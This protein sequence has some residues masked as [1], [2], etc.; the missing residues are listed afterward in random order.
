MIGAQVGALIYIG[1]AVFQ[2]AAMLGAPVG[3]Y[4]QGGSVKGRLPRQRRAAAAVSALVLVLNACA[5]LG[6]TGTGPL[7]ELESPWLE[8]LWW[9]TS[10][11]AVVGAALNLATRSR[12]ERLVFG[13]LSLIL[14]VFVRLV[15]LSWPPGVIQR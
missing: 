11:G 6:V 1:I 12:K 2:C 7:A 8:L 13:P 4:M 15:H 5:I 3:E 9:L 14:L 10:A